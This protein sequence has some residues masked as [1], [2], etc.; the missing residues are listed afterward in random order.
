MVDR[1]LCRRLSDTGFGLL[2]RHRP[3]RSAGVVHDILD[4]AGATNTSPWDRVCPPHAGPPGRAAVDRAAATL[5][6]RMAMDR[7]TGISFIYAFRPGAC[8]VNAIWLFGCRLAK[9]PGRTRVV[10]GGAQHSGA[11]V[12]LDRRGAQ[13]PAP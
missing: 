9:D 4:T 8:G 6:T 11:Q 7:A 12:V 10:L 2:R 1:G 5:I 13:A 3:T